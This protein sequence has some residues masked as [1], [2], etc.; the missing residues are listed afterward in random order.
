MTALPAILAASA[1]A[2]AAAAERRHLDALR[3]AGATAPERA[4]PLEQL[5]LSRDDAFGRLAARGVV[6]QAG[7]GVYLD[8]VAFIAH[9]DRPAGSPRA[10]LVLTLLLTLLVVVLA[11]RMLL[12]S[13]DRARDERE[14]VREAV[15]R[16]RR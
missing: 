16:G 7:G 10:S 5:D 2:A 12:R 14:P 6:R 11:L 9:R 15:E 4:R 13:R 3:I 1:S 8:E